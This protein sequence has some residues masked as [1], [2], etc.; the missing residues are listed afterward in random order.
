MDMK[1]RPFGS[2]DFLD[3]LGEQATGNI[4]DLMVL[5]PLKV[6]CWTH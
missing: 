6:L 2:M 4:S 1:P 5:S 3:S